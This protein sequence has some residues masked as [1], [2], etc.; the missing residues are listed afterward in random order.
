MPPGD[1][2]LRSGRNAR[3]LGMLCYIT[4]R[5]CCFWRGLQRK[6]DSVTSLRERGGCNTGMRVN[7]DERSCVHAFTTTICC[8]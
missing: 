6:V 4:V 2:S 5:A 1:D 7:H 3:A 8:N